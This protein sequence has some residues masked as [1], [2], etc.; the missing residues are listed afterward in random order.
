MTFAECALVIEGYGRQFA[1]AED[2]THD[3]RPEADPAE[4][5]AA[6]LEGAKSGN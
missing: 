1:S 4:V 5:V 2:E 6:M 3:E